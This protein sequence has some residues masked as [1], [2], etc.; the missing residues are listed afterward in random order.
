MALRV[1]YNDEKNDKLSFKDLLD[2]DGAMSIHDSN[3]HK[4]AIETY[5]I[6]NDLSPLPIQELFINQAN[7]YDLR[8][9][10][11]WQVPEVRTVAY[12]SETI[13]YN[14]PNTWD[15]LPSE[16]KNAK[17][18]VEFKKIKYWQPQGCTCRLCLNYIYHYG[19]V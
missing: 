5:K 19:F 8:K 16:I 1:I 13:R 18:I 3:L 7:R 2:K 9:K 12:G 11:S 15:L 4:L 6:E 17:T 14:G 10:R